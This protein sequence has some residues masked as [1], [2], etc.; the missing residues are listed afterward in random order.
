VRD[1]APAPGG[2][3]ILSPT[4]QLPN[5]PTPQLPNSLL[6]PSPTLSLPYSLPPLPI[7]KYYYPE[8]TPTPATVREQRSCSGPSS[9]ARVLQQADPLPVSQVLR[10]TTGERIAQSLPSRP[11]AIHSPTP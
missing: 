6:S 5:S 11:E 1:S 4:P 3:L 9:S 10:P 7:Q 2:V 8:N